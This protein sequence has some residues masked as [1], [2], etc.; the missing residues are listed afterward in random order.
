MRFRES[1]FLTGD[2]LGLSGACNRTLGIG[3]NFG[4]ADSK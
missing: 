2:A 4:E 1:K 3:A